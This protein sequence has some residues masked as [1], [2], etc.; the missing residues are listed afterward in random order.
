VRG[1]NPAAGRELVLGA[2][3]L[4]GVALDPQGGLIV[5]SNDVIWRLDVPLQPLGHP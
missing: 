5:A 1:D 2:P 4:V 3:A